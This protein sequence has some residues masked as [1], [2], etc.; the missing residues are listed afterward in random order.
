MRLSSQIRRHLA[1]L[2]ALLVLTVILGIAYPVA[3]W[4]VAFIPGL[5]HRAQGSMV[6]TADGRIV[7]SRIIGQS[8]TD[9]DGDPLKQYVQSRPS[10]AGDGYDPTSTSASNLGPESIVDTLPD[11]A[12]V[13]AGKEDA[14]AKT[15]LLT[16]VCTRSKKVGELEGVSGA[17]P[18]CTP[19]GIGAVLAVMGPRDGQGHVTHPTRVVSLNEECGVVARPFVATYDGVPVECAKYGEDYAKGEVVP[20]R[21]GAPA[22]PVVPA[23][24]VTASGSGLD[25]HISPA[26]ARL[27]APRIARTRGVSEQRVLA[28]IKD[29]EDGRVLG[30]AGEPRVNVLTLNIELDEKY[31]YR[32]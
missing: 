21:G 12:L 4:A 10:N 30:F 32:G 22:H 2:R 3:I 9:K 18:F 17:R 14:N 15:S 23:D 5:H 1:A 25:P 8:F 29:N 24:A 7:G 20:V 31:P 16:Q 13:K 27:Q 26:Y 11:P 6:R 28:A 19:G